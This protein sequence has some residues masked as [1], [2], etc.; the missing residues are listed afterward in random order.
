MFAGGITNIGD[1]M[2]DVGMVQYGSFV[3]DKGEEDYTSYNAAINRIQHVVDQVTENDISFY[4]MESKVYRRQGGENESMAFGFNGIAHSTSTLNAN[5]I[6]MFNNMGYASQSHWTKYLG[7]TPFSDALLGIKYVITKDDL[8]DSRYYETAYSALEHAD[9]VTP[10]STIYAMEN[11]YALPIEYGVSPFTLEGLTGMS[12]P[13]YPNAADALNKITKSLLLNKNYTDNIYGPIHAIAATDDCVVE[14]FSQPC[15]YI[16]DN[17]EEQTISVPY[18]SF[19]VNGEKPTI[20]F[21]FNMQAN[22]RLYAHFPMDNFGKAC[23]IYV[24]GRFVCTYDSAQVV[25]LGEFQ[26]SEKITVELRLYDVGDYDTDYDNIYFA[27]ESNFYFFYSNYDA[28]L[29]ALEYLSEAAMKVE[30]YSNTS[31][32][33][34]INLPE[35]QDFILTTIPYDEGW[36]CYID[37]EEAEITKALG[38]LISVKSTAGEHEIEFR[39]MPKCY[40]IGFIV[41]GVGIV[42]FAAIIVYTLIK[43]KRDAKAAALA[44]A[45]A[46]E[47]EAL[48]EEPEETAETKGSQ[49]K[50]K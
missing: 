4:R 30:D 16:D 33:G 47:A 13:Y 48:E 21:V 7:G 29:K 49:R 6:R 15:K 17:G 1:V 25:D 22:S 32:K 43:K 10:V 18:K 19:K 28:Q 14:Y 39:Y 23:D 9:H 42:S 50:R 5:I 37:G 24:N 46:A 34:K 41:S 2:R 31:I 36:T 44:E 40:V 26:K 3:N 27:N 45:S 38:S 8:L 35:G 12:Q 20:R 11:K